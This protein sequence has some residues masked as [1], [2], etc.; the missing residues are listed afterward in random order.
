VAV[1][2]RVA[3]DVWVCVAVGG[4]VAL[5]VAVG[6]NV[7]VAVGDEVAVGLGAKKRRASR[8]LPPPGGPCF[9]TRSK[10]TA[11]KSTNVPRAKPPLRRSQGITYRISMSKLT[12]SAS[13]L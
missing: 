9:A 3:V 2:V 8:G 4:K 5:A 12:I 1:L 7:G 10:A 6:V 13:S 11:D